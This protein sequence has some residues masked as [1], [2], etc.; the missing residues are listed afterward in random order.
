MHL[1]IFFWFK[2]YFSSMFFCCSSSWFKISA[3]LI[4]F[5]SFLC[6]CAL[7]MSCWCQFLLLILLC[8]LLLSLWFFLLLLS[9]WWRF[10]LQ[11]SHNDFALT[12]I[13]QH[14]TQDDFQMMLSTSYSLSSLNCQHVFS[15]LWTLFQVCLLFFSISSAD[16]SCAD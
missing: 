7:T 15:S 9:L 3:V 12:M 4:I 14:W 11:I 6:S 16:S 13:C 8:S 10:L 1:M 5:S 2:N